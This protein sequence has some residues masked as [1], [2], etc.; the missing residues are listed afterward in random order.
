VLFS[1][2][3]SR[4]DEIDKLGNIVKSYSIDSRNY[5]VTSS[6]S[7]SAD[8][9]TI[10]SQNITFALR[11]ATL[12]V[13]TILYETPQEIIFANH[14]VNVAGNGLKYYI[15]IENWVF[16]DIENQLAIVTETISGSGNSLSVTTK[17]VDGGGLQWVQVSLNGMILYAKYLDFAVIDDEVQNVQFNFVRS[18]NSAEVHAIVPHFWQYAE[19]DPDYSVLVD[20]GASEN[21]GPRGDNSVP[22]TTIIAVVASVVG[23]AVIVSIAFWVQLRRRHQNLSRVLQRGSGFQTSSKHLVGEDPTH[24][25]STSAY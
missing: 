23:V 12:I 25:S 7:F 10:I 17:S 1:V 5:T 24:S 6:D 8:N 21:P 15:R 2:L 22:L 18:N 19:I 3:V 20:P 11:E 9:S 14:T 4:V 13:T 16:A